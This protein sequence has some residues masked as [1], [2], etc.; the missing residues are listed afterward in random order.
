MSFEKYDLFFSGQ[1]MNGLDMAEV[2]I[3]VG[4]IFGATE[5]QLNRLF[6]GDPIP[7]KKGVDMDTAVKYRVTLREAGALIDVVPTRSPPTRPPGR[8]ATG[9]SPAAPAED[10]TATA[11][12]PAGATAVSEA[13]AQMT[14]APPRTGTL[15]DCAPETPPT[16]L[17]DISGLDLGAEGEPLVA[18]QAVSAPP[19][20]TSGL[21]LFPANTGDLKDCQPEPPPL[22]LPD[23][24]DLR[25]LDPE[26]EN[27][28]N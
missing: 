21:E 11:T 14:L 16:E 7:I 12:A 24:S 25:L 8:P 22:P 6:S 26:E 10:A 9:G 18:Q 27:P 20:D 4:K 28:G 23:I 19:I 1:I 3:R 5:E 15:E 17:P 2:R 13:G